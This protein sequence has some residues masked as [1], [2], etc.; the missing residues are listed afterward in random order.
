M[1]KCKSAKADWVA[2]LLEHPY[3]LCPSRLHPP[4]IPPLSLQLLSHLHPD[5]DSQLHQCWVGTL[6]CLQAYPK[7]CR[8][9][10]F[11]TDSLHL[12]LFNYV[13]DPSPLPL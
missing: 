13:A 9:W 2:N 4:V 12:K 6:A 8:I 7:L 11:C 5:H 10:T 1:E 3:S